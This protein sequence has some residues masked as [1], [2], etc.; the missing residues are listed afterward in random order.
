MRHDKTENIFGKKSYLYNWSLIYYWTIIRPSK[1]YRMCHIKKFTQL[2]FTREI[3]KLSQT[4]VI[5]NRFSN[6][7]CRTAIL[8]MCRIKQNSLENLSCFYFRRI[9]LMASIRLL[10]TSKQTHKH[11]TTKT[12]FVTSSSQEIAYVT[13]VSTPCNPALHDE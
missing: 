6:I 8:L 4:K 1:L 11:Q 7:I 10:L 2:Y 5:L 3:F 13:A 9:L 12:S